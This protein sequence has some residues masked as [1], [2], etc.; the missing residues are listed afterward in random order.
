MAVKTPVSPEEFRSLL[1]LYDIGGFVGCSPIA[2]G[3]VQTNYR[4]TTSRGS[5]IFRLYENRT[6]NDVRY[7]AAL[8]DELCAAHFPCP[9]YVAPACG[10]I[11]MLHGKPCA[12]FTLLPGSS[13]SSPTPQQTC[14]LVQAAARMSLITRGLTLPPCPERCT[15]HPDW[16]RKYALQQCSLTDAPWAED[17]LHWYNAALDK[18]WLPPELPTGVCH[19]DFHFSNVLFSGD[20][21]CGIVDFDDANNTYLLFDLVCLMDFFRPEFDWNTW[22]SFSPDTD[23]LSFEQPRRILSLY[24]QVR[25]LTAAERKHLFDVLLLSILIDCL[26]YFSRGAADDFFEKRKIES[27]QRLGRSEFYKR[28]FG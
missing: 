9:G 18:L 20:D 26:W 3:S 15:Y 10:S 25:P 4:L 24:Q 12:I 13:V 5:Y 14:Q 2:E 27:L 11:P 16:C 22:H 19:C 7:E 23:I 21:L 8:L 28:L 6:A 17:K 1:Q